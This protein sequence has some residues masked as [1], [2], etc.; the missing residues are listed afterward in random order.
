M[1]P[2]AVVVVDVDAEHVLK[3]S[4]A[5]DQDPVEA[6]AADGADPALGERV[7]LRRPEP[8]ADDLDVLG[9][10]TRFRLR[11]RLGSGQSFGALTPRL[12]RSAVKG[13]QAATSSEASP[14][15]VQ[16]TALKPPLRS[17]RAPSARG[18]TAERQ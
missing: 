18:D 6:V 11:M 17:R 12:S 9:V 1:R 2:M 4:P 7:R 13:R 15:I 10:K 5:D 14:K 3:L 8:C 16:S